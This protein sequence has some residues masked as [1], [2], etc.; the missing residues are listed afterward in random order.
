MT[1]ELYYEEIIRKLHGCWDRVV[2]LP[3][4]KKRAEA[5]RMAN[6]IRNHGYLCVVKSVFGFCFWVEVN[7]WGE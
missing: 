3:P 6:Y 5:V 7:I 1:Q 4:V 2:N